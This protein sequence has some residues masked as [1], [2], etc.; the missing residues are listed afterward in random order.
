MAE[1]SIHERALCESEEIGPGTSIGAFA[2]V[3]AGA[4]IGAECRISDGVHLD[5]G[6]PSRWTP[7]EMRHSAPIRAPAETRAK[8]PIDVPGPISSLSHNARSWMEASAIALTP[9]GKLD[10]VADDR[11]RA[12]LQRV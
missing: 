1:A 5:G 11:S 8:A 10:D 12:P 3:S 2:R 4:R 6:P 7:S 9:G